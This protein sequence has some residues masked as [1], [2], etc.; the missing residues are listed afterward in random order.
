MLA[1]DAI[2]ESLSFPKIILPKLDGVKMNNRNHNVAYGRSMKPLP[3]LF[4]Q[5][6]FKDHHFI[7]GELIIGEP[8][9]KDSFNK[10]DGPIR[11]KKGEPDAHIYLF[12][13]AEDFTLPY[14]K[15]LELAHQYAQDANLPHIHA[16]EYKLVHTVDQL[17]HYEEL[18]VTK[19]YEGLIIRDP[20][21][22]YK[23]GRSTVKEGWFLRIKRFKDSEFEII[24]FEEQMENT[25][26][27]V[28]N[29]LGNSK[30]PT[31]AEGMVG[32]GTL[33]AFKARD[34]H[35]GWEF[36]IG[37]GD[38]WD[39]PFKQW[40]WDNREKLLG[41]IFKYRYFPVGMKDKPRF[42]VGIGERSDYDIIVGE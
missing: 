30:R 13:F 17:L 31:H 26:E 34:I 10:T 4:T 16:V 24:G 38:G 27:A 22:P 11:T 36:S 29:E 15:R 6:R 21:A 37:N 42:P 14:Y 33:G 41:K 23:N 18:W 32:K 3:N 40:A 1:E 25:N 28:V 2:I 7:E 20:N 12:D 35:H 39:I 5:A 19:G 8:T 9:A